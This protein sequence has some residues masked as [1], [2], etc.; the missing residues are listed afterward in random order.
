MSA[1]AAPIAPRFLSEKEAQAVDELLRQTVVKTGELG[2]SVAKMEG[3]VE[4]LSEQQDKIAGT[5]DGVVENQAEF[6]VWLT[7]LRTWMTMKEK[8]IH[9][10]WGVIVVVSG[11][12]V[13][14]FSHLSLVGRLLGWLE[15]L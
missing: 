15:S 5:L 10:F 14:L 3:A 1:A 4:R 13:W 12:L 7:E 8:M 2:A 6:K 9:S 11:G